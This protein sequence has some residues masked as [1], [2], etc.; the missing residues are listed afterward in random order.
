MAPKSLPRAAGADATSE[1]KRRFGGGPQESID[2]FDTTS[3][4]FLALPL[5]VVH[6]VQA[7]WSALSASNQALDQIGRTIFNV[8]FERF[9]EARGLFASSKSAHAAKFI[10]ALGN[11]VAVLE[12]PAEVKIGVQSLGFKHI[13][14]EVTIPAVLALRVAVLQVMHTSLGD[15]LSASAAE[16]WAQLLNYCGGALIFFRSTLADRVRVLKESWTIAQKGTNLQAGTQGATKDSA[17]EGSGE[18]SGESGKS[19][20]QG[21]ATATDEEKVSMS[22]FQR[23]MGRGKMRKTVN[24]EDTAHSAMDADEGCSDSGD[25]SAKFHQQQQQQAAAVMT[26]SFEEMFSINASVMGVKK[27]SL[28][29]MT[30]VLGTFDSVVMNVNDWDRFQEECDVLTIRISKYAAGT[31]ILKQFRG[32]LLAALRSLLPKDWSSAHEDAWTWLWESVA[33]VLTDNLEKPPTYEKAYEAALTGMDEN[34]KFKLRA[35]LYTRFFEVA[36]AGQDYFKQSNTRLHFIAERVLEMSL[37]I[38]QSPKQMVSLISALGLRHVGFGIPTD[39]FPPFIK[40]YIEIMTKYVEDETVVQAF[41]WSLRLVA[42][43]LVRTIHEGSTVVMKSINCNSVKLLKRAIIAAPRKLRAMWMLDVQVGD[44]HISPLAWSIESG[45]LKVTEAVL[46]DLLTIRADRMRYYYG[47]DTLWSRHPDIVKKLQQEAPMLLT[48]LL[49]GLIWRSHRTVDGMRRVNYYVKHVLVKA[50]GTFA[51]ALECVSGTGDP[52]LV[53]HPTV[54]LLADCLWTGVVVRQFISSRMWNVFSLGVF[55]MAQ[56]VWPSWNV[57][58]QPHYNWMIFC[59][60]VFNYSVGMGRL[61][62]FHLYRIWVWCRNTMRRII[63]EIDTDGNGEIDYEEMKEALQKFKETVSEEVKKAIRALKEEGPGVDEAKKAIA[64]R[65]KNMYNIISFSLLVLLGVMLS[66]EPMFWC[67]DAEKWPTEYCDVT[68][69]P[70]SPTDLKYRYSIFAMCAMAVHWLILIDLAVF[71]TEISAFLLVCGHVLAEVKQFLMALTFL[72]FAFGSTI[73]IWCTDC[74]TMGGDFGDMPNAVISLFAITVGLYQGDFRQ[75]QENALLLALVTT[76]VS[77]SVVLLLNLLVAQLSRSYEYIYTD[78]L[79]FARLNRASLLVD[80]MESCS[81]VR[82]RRFVKSLD[83]EKRL[84][85]DEGDLGLSGGIASAEPASKHIQTREAIRRYG[86][87]TSGDAPWPIT[88]EDSNRNEDGEEADQLD[89]M[90]ELVNK[91]ARR[92]NQLTLDAPSA[93][94]ALGGSS[95]LSQDMSSMSGEDESQT[96]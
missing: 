54:A 70:G 48:T 31:V 37:E 13:G 85:F 87:T 32:C 21:S 18:H 29:W 23:M 6:E 26:T 88:Q 53:S 64:N 35:D 43:I 68:G 3:F 94:A 1:D 47:V 41:A 75:F 33:K 22:R 78:M 40:S 34:H 55:I 81:R 27:S 15:Q 50:D 59:G 44:Q 65:E 86:G 91:I 57:P 51:D 93:A 79:G 5:E 42:K 90:E 36:P 58:E 8:F 45:S 69:E 20:P 39:L 62:T 89:E 7:S 71:S 14:I 72:L 16:G 61:A 96:E 46:N 24:Q 4:E 11:I 10:K 77:I 80:A 28:E 30:E 52:T 92:V 74:P 84:E 9:P 49:E 66:H 73:S 38:Y 19:V 95:K 25:E 76:F 67:S 56:E 63:K 17:E 12:D 60:R 2:S 82:W 83:F